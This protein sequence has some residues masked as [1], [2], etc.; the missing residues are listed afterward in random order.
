MDFVFVSGRPSLDFVGTRK[1]RRDSAEE[2]LLGAADLADWTVRAGL[3]DVAPRVDASGL[4]H[5]IE[6]RE[7][8]Y[9]LLA[10][11]ASPTRSSARDRRRLNAVG[12][13][14]PVELALRGQRVRRSGDLDAV[15]ATLARDAIEIIGTDA[16]A[17]VRE[18]TN[19]RCTRLFLDASRGRTRRWCGMSECGN[20]HKVAAFR[21][22]EGAG[23]IR[24]GSTR[25]PR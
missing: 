7:S 5:A 2:Q 8:M 1:W 20:R 22:R 4:G 3:L 24:A 25:A 6:L 21:E 14:P 18:C 12:A 23:S 13:R 15:L 9:R 10:L 16:M 11:T 19:E 17:S